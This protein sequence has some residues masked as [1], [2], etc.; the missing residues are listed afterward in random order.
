MEVKPALSVM[1]NEIKVMSQLSSDAIKLIHSTH[2]I[3]A[4]KKLVTVHEL[5]NLNLSVQKDFS[6]S[7]EIVWDISALSEMKLIRH[8]M[9]VYHSRDFD[10]PYLLKRFIEKMQ[11][12]L[13]TA[14][15]RMKITI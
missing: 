7:E 6:G 11:S 13:N 4:I 3:T 2:Q 12:I 8:E 1:V 14:Q 15:H 5:I 10:P 9:V